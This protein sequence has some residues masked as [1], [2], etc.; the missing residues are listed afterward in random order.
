MIVAAK[1]SSMRA[2]LLGQA[3]R[4]LD[5]DDDA[6]VA[7]AVALQPRHALAAQHEHLAGLGAGGDLDG[8]RAVE[9]RHLE[10]RAE[11]RQRRRHV[12][13]RDQVVAVAHEALVLAH[14]DQHVEVAG[15]AAAAR[16]RGRGR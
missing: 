11:R 3:P 5:V 16:R 9:R 14:V 4:D 8:G 10:A 7:V 12:E 2:L 1:R 13:R 6:Q 15:R